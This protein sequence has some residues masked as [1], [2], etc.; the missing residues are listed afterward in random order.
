MPFMFDMGYIYF[1]LPAFIF[2]MIAQGMVSRR[3]RKY[4]KVN[5]YRGM[6]GEQAAQ[7]V[8]R[9][10]GVYNVRI[11]RVSGHLTDHFDPKSNVIRLSSGVHDSVSIAAVGIAAHEA[12]HAVQYAQNYAPMRIRHAIIP[13]TQVGSTLSMPLILIGFFFNSQLGQ[14]LFLA[15]I[16]LF[17]AVAL[18]QLVTLP[19][20][21][22]ASNRA[23]RTLEEIRLLDTDELRGAK[24]VLSAAA[25]T[26]V[27]ALA[28]SVA[29]LLRLILLFNG[30]SRD[31]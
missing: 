5:N 31:E 13:M 18:F 8:L 16:V 10:N 6:S 14:T 25:L 21:F 17:G 11:E 30:R 7:E 28:T 20:E 27:A 15:G 24:K 22:N 4:S 19:V 29:E 12:G 26:Y 3:F 23:M 9:A 2:A 1:V